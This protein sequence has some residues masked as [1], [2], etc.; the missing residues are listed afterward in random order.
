MISKVQVLR[1][2]VYDFNFIDSNADHKYQN[3]WY[4]FRMLPTLGLLWD[5]GSQGLEGASNTGITN[6]LT[7]PT[8]VTIANYYLT[9]AALRHR[10]L[11]V[12]GP[13]NRLP[14]RHVQLTFD[15]EK[16]RTLNKSSHT[17]IEFINLLELERTASFIHGH[18]IY[19]PGAKSR[20]Y[21]KLTW[22]VTSL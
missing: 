3:Y 17:E 14:T 2:L 21:I 15:A 7:I 11:P 18:F 22:S 1:A 5:I 9:G 6:G 10:A 8:T 4:Y 19:S 20:A 16:P 13:Y 12:L